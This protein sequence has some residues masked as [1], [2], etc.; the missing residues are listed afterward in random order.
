MNS[1]V[2]ILL[3]LVVALLAAAAHAGATCPNACGEALFL[4]RCT[5][6]AD[7]SDSFCACR[8]G[9]A[10]DDCAEAVTG[11]TF[12][13][14]SADATEHV[15][16]SVDVFFDD[17]TLNVAIASPLVAERN[18]TRIAIDDSAFN[19]Q[20]CTYPGPHWSRSFNACQDVF[21]AEL[22]WADNGAC[23]W[24]HDQ[25]GLSLA[26]YSAQMVVEHHD[27]IDPFSSREQASPVERFTQHVIPLT[28]SFP[29]DVTVSSDIA[30]QS[31]VKLLSAISK[32]TVA[33]NG[34]SAVVEITTNLIWPYTLSDFVIT[35]NPG[36]ATSYT[37][38]LIS[39]DCDNDG[40]SSCTQVFRIDI[41]NGPACTLNGQYSLEWTLQCQPDPDTAELPAECAIQEGDTVT[42]T[43]NIV[44]E[45]FCTSIGTSL[46]LSGTLASYGDFART[47]P[48]TQF[49]IGQTLYYRASMDSPN[50]TLTGATIQSVKLT[51]PGEADVLLYSEGA[52]ALH[53]TEGEFATTGAISHADF[54]FTLSDE[55]ISS[56]ADDSSRSY[57]TIVIVGVDYQD[58]V[59]TKRGRQI[60]QFSSKLN[61][62]VVA[63]S[64]SFEASHE[65]ASASTVAFT[66][67]VAFVGIAVAHF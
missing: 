15:P 59:T 50:V 61:S 17:D 18:Y 7:T 36:T 37:P 25:T 47:L 39:S 20:R 44:S 41:V 12:H 42:A 4:G 29:K 24:T 22:P 65:T 67:I 19:D 40:S 26:V 60:V 31:A 38:S 33:P 45:N 16:L 23:G 2:P 64:A 49:L 28:I 56:I 63:L 66:G 30:V 34:A 57:T 58:T 53:G 3:A 8:S 10:G 35:S 9:Q 21:T 5:T 46:P 27:S 13:S 48:K 62:Q 32:Q 6:F 55:F 14:L 54:E 52:L 51:S 1:I 43:L 11:C